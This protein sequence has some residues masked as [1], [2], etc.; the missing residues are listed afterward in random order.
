MGLIC[1]YAAGSLFYTYSLHGKTFGVTLRGHDSFL[2]A[3]LSNYECR[4]PKKVQ[5]SMKLRFIEEP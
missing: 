5:Y 4:H 1:S 3:L 2:G